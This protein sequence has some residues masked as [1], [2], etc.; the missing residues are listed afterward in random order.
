MRSG[1][2]LQWQHRAA[3]GVHLLCG[4]L[5]PGGVI[6]NGGCFMHARRL[7]VCWGRCGPRYMH[8]RRWIVLPCWLMYGPGRASVVCV[9]VRE[10]E[11]LLL[12]VACDEI[13]VSC[14]VL[15]REERTCRDCLVAC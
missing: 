4:R 9:C 6:V 5:L 10:R 8:M 14:A 2:V 7:V 3:H 12:S 1:H 11:M 15:V 13:C